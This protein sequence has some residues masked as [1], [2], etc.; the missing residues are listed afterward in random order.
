MLLAR[1]SVE[2]R[3]APRRPCA[4]LVDLEGWPEP[5]TL[6]SR[7][8]SEGGVFL[9]HQ[10]PPPLSTELDL[11][12][13][14]HGRSIRVSGV[15]VHHLP[16]IGFGVRFHERADGGVDGLDEFLATIESMPAAP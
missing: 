11:R 12:L 2:R 3:R 10:R 9:Y 15:V 4:L 7:D 13:R 16:G 14:S 6:T 8:V 1:I 5:L